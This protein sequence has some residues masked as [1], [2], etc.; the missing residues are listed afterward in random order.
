MYSKKAVWAFI[1]TLIHPAA[2]LLATILAILFSFALPSSWSVGGVIGV[3]V[4]LGM[5]PGALLSLIGLIITI[6][7]FFDLRKNSRL[8]GKFYAWASIVLV[9]IEVL[10]I[11]FI[12][13]KLSNISG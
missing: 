1:L 12:H 5:M 11:S 8:E 13:S 7:A 9:A 3:V 4:I 6:L 10:I 2:I